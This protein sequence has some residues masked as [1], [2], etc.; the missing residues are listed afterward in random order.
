[1]SDGC[2]SQRLFLR[3]PACSPP[4]SYRPSLAPTDS[5]THVSC[6]PRA[7]HSPISQAAV[8]VFDRSAY[9]ETAKANKISRSCVLCG[10]QNI[11]L[12]GK[13]IIQSGAV[14][15]GDLAQ[16]RIG[17]YCILRKDCVLR[18]P[19]KALQ[20]GFAFYPMQ[21]GTNVIIGEGSV[22]EAASVGSNVRIGAGCVVARRCILKDCCVL[23]DDTVL[24]PDTVVPPFS[25]FSGAPGR[26]VAE[27]P[28]C[29]PELFASECADIFAKF[30]SAAPGTARKSAE[31]AAKSK[32]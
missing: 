7:Q 8:E 15:R 22:V 10:S 25:V 1:M 30:R 3:S 13:A 18:P 11:I 23:L 5:H 17:R 12:H 26:L 27:L 19:Y 21:V 14:I 29:V 31:P 4:L 6:N 32:E 20:R 24:A 16:V 9:I 2:P 28:E